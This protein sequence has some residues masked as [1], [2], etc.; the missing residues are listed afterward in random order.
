MQ[1]VVNND[2]ARSALNL[3]QHLADV[4]NRPYKV[5]SIGQHLRVRPLYSKGTHSAVVYPKEWTGG[6]IHGE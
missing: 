5:V 2:R 4:E 1:D 6:P 3:A